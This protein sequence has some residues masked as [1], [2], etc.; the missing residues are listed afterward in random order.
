MKASWLLVLLLALLFVGHLPAQQ[1][2]LSSQ[3]IVFGDAFELTVTAASDFEPARLLPLQVELLDRSPVGTQ[4]QW[5]FRARCYEVGRVTLSLDPPVQ[6]TVATSL[7][8]PRGELEWPGNGWLL[9]PPASSSWL[10]FVVVGVAL[11]AG[12]LWWR[13]SRTPPVVEV[14]PEAAAAPDWDAMAALQEL[15]LPSKDSSN[16]TCQ[17]YY[18]QLKSIVRRH[19]QARFRVPAD[20]RTSEELV[21]AL[22][23]AQPTLQ[24]CLSTCDVVLFGGVFGADQDHQRAKDTAIAFVAATSTAT[25]SQA[26]VTS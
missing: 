11:L 6:F 3:P 4:Q 8:E 9:K 16:G 19:C 5:R 14:V 10:V 23:K 12:L 24:P 22:P 20:M 13:F 2:T 21:L 26:E 7:P 18:Q 15:M 25:R 1:V 17:P